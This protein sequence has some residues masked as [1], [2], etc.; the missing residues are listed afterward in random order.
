M[1]SCS[2]P[3][4]PNQSSATVTEVSENIPLGQV[5]TDTAVSSLTAAMPL[6]E[7]SAERAGD[8]SAVSCEHQAASSDAAGAVWHGPDGMAEAGQNS[9]LP[10]PNEQRAGEGKESFA[11]TKRAAKRQKTD[12]LPQSGRSDGDGICGSSSRPDTETYLVRVRVFQEASNKVAVSASI[13]AGEPRA[14]AEHFTRTL[15]A[16]QMDISQIHS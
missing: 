5:S 16:V 7:V 15:K 2:G 6:P 1:L 4:T 11:G 10:V 14:V 12:Q 8:V 13:A 9:G 3:P